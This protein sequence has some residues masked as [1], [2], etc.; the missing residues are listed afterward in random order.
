MKIQQMAFSV[1]KSR[2]LETMRAKRRSRQ[3]KLLFMFT[4][5]GRKTH[6]VELSMGMKL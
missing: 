4:K 6:T 5:G 1:D 2:N 3:R